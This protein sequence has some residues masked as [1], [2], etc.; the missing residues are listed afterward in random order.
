MENIKKENL[1]EDIKRDLAII[2]SQKMD[3]ELEKNKEKVEKVDDLDTELD[4]FNFNEEVEEKEEDELTIKLHKPIENIKE[5][6]LDPE[7][8]NGIVLSNIEK[9]WRSKNKYRDTIKELDGMYLALVASTMSGIKYSTIM[10]LGGKDYTRVISRVRNFLL[11][12]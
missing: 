6:V 8:V 7:K 12:D 11:V 1:P 5:V 4:N 3:A 9:T 10:N 2:E